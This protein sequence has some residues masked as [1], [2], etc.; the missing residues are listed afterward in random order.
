M[1]IN[2]QLFIRYLTPRLLAKPLRLAWLYLIITP[3]RKLYNQFKDVEEIAIY[4]ARHSCLKMYL[5]KALNDA[6]D[7]L[8]RGIYI[9]N[10]GNHS[11]LYLYRKGE[12]RPI[13][14]IYKKGEINVFVYPEKLTFVKSKEEYF[15]TNDFVVYVPSSLVLNQAELSELVNSYKAVGKRFT[16]DTY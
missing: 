1:S 8:G 16:I 7:P 2:W 4:S 11:R 12:P 10:V 15:G 13:K 14:Y 3:V 9:D 6:F 5:E